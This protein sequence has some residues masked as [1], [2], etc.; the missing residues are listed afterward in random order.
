MARPERH[1]V[2]YFPFFAKRGKTLNILQN[3]FGL[4]G[5]GFFTNLMRFLALTPDHYYCIKEEDD[6]LNF[7]AEIGIQE[8]EKGLA[9]IELMV[10]TEKLDKSLWENHMVIAC[11]A[12]LNSLEEA[13]RKRSNEIITIEKI[14]S[15]FEE[16]K[17]SGVNSA[18]NPENSAVNPA[19]CGLSDKISDNNPQSKV[20]KS[21]V[22]ESKYSDS[23]ESP[24]KNNSF[25]IL[26]R[27]PK[28]DK[29]RVEK[30]WLINYRDLYGALPI[31]PAWSISA[32][33]I[34]KAVDQV[35]I[36]KVLQALETAKKD[37]FCLKSGYTLQIIM[38]S[39]VISKLVNASKTI[40]P[41]GLNNK[42]ELGG[43]K[44]WS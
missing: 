34:K 12:F 36:E 26:D 41:P 30:Q 10:K 32:P 28:N 31:N 1:D 14:R 21:K 29:E 42:K 2:D 9:M 13:Y 35:G 25:A 44:S 19:V 3:K 7:F 18:V 5:I 4:E 6:R 20:K 17:G 27:E 37:E 22:K 39:S 11:E 33:R 40:P 15:I 16:N 8:E 43:L 38:S 23:D 24:N